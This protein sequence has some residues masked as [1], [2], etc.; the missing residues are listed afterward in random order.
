MVTQL[1]ETSDPRAL[2]PGDPAGIAGVAGQLYNYAALLT[3][4]GNGLQ[5]IDTKSGWQGA[6]ADAFRARFR[7]QPGAWIEAGSCFLSAARALDGYVPVLSWAQQEAAEAIT[8]WQ[9]GNKRS[10][11]AILGNAR[12]RVA[13]AAGTATGI[14][15]QARDKAPQA[16]GFW[17]DVGGF[18]ASAWHGI[19][20]VGA[21]AVNG[22]ASTGNAIVTNPGADAGVI[23]GGLLAGVSALGDAGGAVLDATGVGAIIGVPVNALSTAGV[24]AGGT[25]AMASAGDLAS[26]AAGDD[27]VDPVKTGGGDS[28]S[29]AQDPR[30]VPGTSEY[31]EYVDELAKDPAHGGQVD[32]KAEREAAVAVQAEAD[33]DLP[34]PVTRTPFNAEGGD[35]GDFTDGTGQKW[36]VKSSP[37]VRPSYANGPGQPIAR[38]QTDTTFTRMINKEV[39]QG[40]KVLLDPDGMTPDRLAHLQELVANNPEWQGQVVWGR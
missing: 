25:L 26:H 40:Q 28:G 15:G 2:V 4:A 33:G 32:A 3:E 17:S 8:Q 20:D 14:I 10:A 34:G 13:S 29:P 21:D 35:D 22:L 38:P 24:L 12:D 37:D 9:A 31:D 27:R 1:G 30:L 5:R 36:E 19:E 11:Q 6:A 18:L 7:G 23:G 16:P 39:A